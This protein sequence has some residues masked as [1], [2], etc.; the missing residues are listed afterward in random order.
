MKLN[1]DCIRDLLIEIEEVTD[2]ETGIL[3]DFNHENSERLSAYEPN[4]LAYHLNQ[5]NLSGYLVGFRC[6]GNDTFDL[7]FLSPEGHAF[8]ANVRSENVWKHTK[9]IAGKIG[10]WSLDALKNIACGVVSELIRSQIGSSTS[11][12][13]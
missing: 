6:F 4:T 5:C 3:F 13:S 10:V 9:S 12:S 1:P 7:Q 11:P 2:M 8:L